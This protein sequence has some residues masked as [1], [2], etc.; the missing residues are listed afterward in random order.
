MM[1]PSARLGVAMASAVCPIP[2]A[3]MQHVRRPRAVAVFGVGSRYA[4]LLCVALTLTGCEDFPSD[5]ARTVS[6]QQ[7]PDAQWPSELTVADTTVLAIEVRDEDGSPIT[8]LGIRW[9]SSDANVLEVRSLVPPGA[10][11]NDT[12]LGE[13]SVQ[14]IAQRRGE[15]TIS[16][17]VSQPGISST[18]LS[19]AIRVMEHWTSVSAGFT[20]TCG[21][22]INHDAYCWG[23]GLLGNGSVAGSPIPVQ[24]GQ[25]LKFKGVTAGDGHSCGLLLDGTIMCWGS[26]GAGALGNGSAGD[27]AVPVTVSVISILKLAVAGDNYACGVSAESAAFC[28]GNNESWQLGDAFLQPFLPAQGGE[29]SP[30][31]QDCGVLSPLRCSR[32]PR[33]VRDR[34]SDAAPE[35]IPLALSSIAPGVG[36]TCALDSDGAA[37]CWGS[38]S[39]ELGSATKVETSNTSEIAFVH[40]PGGLRFGDIASGNRHTCAIGKTDGIAYCWGLNTHGQLGR[41]APGSSCPFGDPTNVG[42]SELP[43]SVSGGI[44]FRSL[45]AGGNTSCGISADSAVYCWGANDLGQLGDPSARGVCDTGTA[46]T[47]NP[48][49]IDPNDEPLVSVSVGPRHTCAVTVRG[50]AFCWGDSTGGELGTSAATNTGALAPTRVDEPD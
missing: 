41:I 25:D 8:G 17:E 16:A 14:V 32:T 19:R 9:Q 23:S 30:A 7:P 50:A 21:I 6:F 40:V 5:P 35:G 20:H 22:T 39:A 3:L 29:P 28:W 47:P 11:G 18:V 48:V 12:L 46:C 36:H 34:G 45:D 1:T 27:Q 15:A 4:P 10:V 38:G 49:R 26:N 31:F 44:Q 13:L 43:Q 24:V 2:L 42:C 33:R 37:I